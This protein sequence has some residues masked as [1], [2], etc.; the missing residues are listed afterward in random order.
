MSKP[1]VQMK[2]LEIIIAKIQIPPHRRP[3][4]TV[5]QWQNGEKRH[6]ES[7]PDLDS[8]SSISASNRIDVL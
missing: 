1:K 5:S 8:G 6:A 3:Q 7:G 4:E 2:F